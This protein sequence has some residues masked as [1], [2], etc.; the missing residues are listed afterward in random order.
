MKELKNFNRIRQKQLKIIKKKENNKI[1]ENVK[2]KKKNFI[3]K[4]ERI[5][6]DTKQMYKTGI[7]KFLYIFELQISFHNVQS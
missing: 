7:K 2:I 1:K 3:G 4:K 5:L 6:N